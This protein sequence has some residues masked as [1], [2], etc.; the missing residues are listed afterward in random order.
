MKQAL[1]QLCKS[2]R[3]GYVMNHY[4]DIPFTSPE[5]Y[6]YEVLLAEKKEREMGKVRRLLKKARF[7]QLKT[8]DD[9]TYESITFPVSLTKEKLQSLEFIQQKQNV[10]MLG[11]VGTGKTHL[12][13][14]LGIEAC[15]QGCEVRFFRVADLVSLLQNKHQSGGL[16]R[17]KREMEKCDLLI[18]DELGFV[19][20]HKDGSEL[21]FHLI[22]ECYE[23]NSVIV[24][25]NLE[26]AQWTSVFGDNRLT[27]ALI[28]RLIHHAHIL[29]F[30]GESYRF[31]YAL[32]GN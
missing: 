7:H 24:T 12:A 8:L 2:L 25:S 11:A 32:S 31:G 26:F 18:L 4:E 16:A 3:L 9:Y 22:S 17:F 21:F 29:A 20:F 13:T 30:T 14:A 5:Q 1:K 23:R 15:K 19:P 28:D 6:L 27:G 10:L